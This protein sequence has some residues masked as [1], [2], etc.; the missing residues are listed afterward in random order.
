MTTDGGKDA[1]AAKEGHC[2]DVKGIGPD[3][4]FITDRRLSDTALQASQWADKKIARHYPGWALY[5]LFAAQ[6]K[7][8]AETVTAYA[9]SMAIAYARARKA[10]E[11]PHPVIARRNRGMWIV[12]AAM[13]AVYYGIHQRWPASYIER[14][15]AF[16]VHK[17][18]YQRVRNL[19]AGGLI[20]AFEA[21]RAELFWQWYRAKEAE[22]QEMPEKARLE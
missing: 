3:A 20:T 1:Q 18:G 7:I 22:R 14:A 16:G 10:T 5:R 19:T 4:H 12:Q 13:D 21:Y 17:D 15:E 11:R 9:V 6:D 2:Y 8:H